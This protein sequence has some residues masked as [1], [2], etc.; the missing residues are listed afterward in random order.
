VP[1]DRGYSRFQLTGEQFDFLDYLKA[2]R[3]ERHRYLHSLASN[4]VVLD[5]QAI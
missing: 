2:G 1:P 3:A 5:Q 4:P